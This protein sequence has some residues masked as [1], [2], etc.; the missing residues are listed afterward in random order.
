MPEALNAWP[1]SA[2]ADDY[3]AR[4]MQRLGQVEAAEQLLE[5]LDT[6]AV[7]PEAL[8]KEEQGAILLKV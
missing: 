4:V 6:P 2:P 5:Q 7:E 1:L 8:P 3:A